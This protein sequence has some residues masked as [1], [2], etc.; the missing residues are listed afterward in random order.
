MTTNNITLEGIT[1]N[2]NGVE[3]AIADLPQSA[4]TAIAECVIDDDGEINHGEG[5]VTVAGK[6]YS[7]VA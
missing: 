6:V 5:S 3:I 4:A 7:W 1:L 2:L